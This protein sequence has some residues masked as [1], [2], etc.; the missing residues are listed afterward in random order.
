MKKKN[1]GG[2][3]KSSHG[4]RES[5]KVGFFSSGCFYIKPCKSEGAAGNKNKTG[6]PSDASKRFNR[7][8]I[9]EHGR[10]N[11]KR[12]KIRE[13]IIL[14]SKFG[15]AFG[16]ARHSSVQEIKNARDKNSYH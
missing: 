16:Q 5:F 1:R 10:G 13:G 15:S 8:K 14:F 7:P 11:S 2:N 12:H 3:D 4:D 9:H 6:Q